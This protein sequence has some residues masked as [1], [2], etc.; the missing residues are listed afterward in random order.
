MTRVSRIVPA[1]KTNRPHT[2]ASQTRDSELARVLDAYL[3]ALEA[4]QAIDPTALS[5]A[6]PEIAERILA[7]LSVL[8]VAVQVGEALAGRP[9]LTPRS[10]AAGRLV[11][12][13]SAS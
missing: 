12:A 8:R 3:A 1:G 10:Q 6:H 7:C 9:T 5:A 2:D 13:T 4:G 11:S